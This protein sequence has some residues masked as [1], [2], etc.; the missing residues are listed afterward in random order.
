MM[1]ACCSPEPPA[2]KRTKNN[3]ILLISIP[4]S[5][6]LSLAA[7]ACCLL[8]NSSLLQLRTLVHSVQR[9]GERSVVKTLN[10]LSSCRSS[11]FSSLSPGLQNS[12]CVQGQKL[13]QILIRKVVREHS[14]VTIQIASPRENFGERRAEGERVRE[15]E[16]K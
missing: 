11:S 12:E 13:A 6:G 7:P 16:R 1:L 9:L 2:N 10:F 4:T 8:Y 14:S 5:S 3:M 15:K